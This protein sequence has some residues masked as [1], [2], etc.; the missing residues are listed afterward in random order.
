[1]ID[2]NVFNIA[3][4]GTFDDCQSLMKTVFADL[5]FKDDYNL[6]AVNSINWAR[7]LAQVVYYFYSA[8]CVMREKGTSSVAFSVPTGN[9]GDI[10]AGYLAHQMGLPIERLILAT[11]TNDILSRF[12]QEGDYSCG[13]VAA[14]LS[15]SMDIQ[16]ASNFERYLYYRCGEDPERLASIMSRFSKDGA[17]DASL[18]NA[19]PD[20]VIRAGKADD[21][22]TLDTIRKVW[23]DHNYLLDPHSAVGWSVAE[24]VKCDAPVI[25]LATAHPAK[26]PAA[27][28][29]AV[30]EDIARD[31]IIEALEGLPTECSVMDPVV[32]DVKNLIKGAQDS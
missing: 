31:P 6:G 20:G 4:N 16:I 30:G 17:L 25:C 15:P 26:F 5:A 29:D 22:A 10:F 13:E 21:K 27:G 32:E 1:V 14:T 28:K 3:V 12:F 2:D 7:I 24:S 8:F 23:R 11:N 18:L 19:E 9:F